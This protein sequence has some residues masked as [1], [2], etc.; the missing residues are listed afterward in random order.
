MLSD[1]RTPWPSSPTRGKLSTLALFWSSNTMRPLRS[2]GLPRRSAIRR[3]YQLSSDLRV[4]GLALH[5]HARIVG[6]NRQP[7]MG[8]AAEPGLGGS[9]PLHGRAF[10]V[11]PLLL[12]PAGDADRITHVLHPLRG[13]SP[14]ADLLSLIDAARRRA[15]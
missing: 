6:R 5:V 9:I 1:T 14:L 10:A 7:G 2:A 15:K 4:G 13:G 12:R 8:I 3:R 11:A